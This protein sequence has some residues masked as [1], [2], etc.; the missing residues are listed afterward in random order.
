MNIP[1]KPRKGPTLADVCMLA[2][3]RGVIVS[4]Y[5]QEEDIGRVIPRITV[6]IG[7]LKKD[8]PDKAFKM[9]CHETNP[10]LNYMLGKAIWDYVDKVR[11]QR[12][13]ITLGQV[14]EA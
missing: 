8:V 10:D 7:T 14:G 11:P 12:Q 3:Q 9:D 4:V 1:R 5:V 2:A 13:I 6:R